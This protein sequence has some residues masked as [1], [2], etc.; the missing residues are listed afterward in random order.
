MA[1]LISGL[2]LGGVQRTMLTLA[3]GLADRGL[4]VDL[5]VPAAV[6]AAHPGWWVAASPVGDAD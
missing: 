6:I 4:A 5:L 1:L 2:G 3:G